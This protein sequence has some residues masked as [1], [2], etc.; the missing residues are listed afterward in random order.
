MSDHTKESKLG[1]GDVGCE[2]HNLTN[3]DMCAA[4]KQRWL[5][6]TWKFL[7]TCA[8][9]ATGPRSTVCLTPEGCAAL[10]EQRDK[11]LHVLG[12]IRDHS[13]DTWAKGLARQLIGP[14][15]AQPVAVAP[16]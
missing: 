6:E 16:T 7:E 15:A 12:Q 13:T 2:P 10:L 14:A 11:Q 3:C 9:T 8:A 4:N 1:G 5:E